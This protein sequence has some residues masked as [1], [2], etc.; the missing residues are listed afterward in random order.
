MLLSTGAGGSI[1][2]LIPSRAASKIAAKAKYGLQL[3]SGERSSTLVALPRFAGT[4]NRALLLAKDQAKYTGA[5]YPGTKRLKL[6]TVGFK[7]A[8]ILFTCFKIPPIE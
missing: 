4:L 8:V 7:T 2:F 3:G 1:L 5:S 6:F